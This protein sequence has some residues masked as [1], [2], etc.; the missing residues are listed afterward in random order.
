M[1]GREQNCEITSK[2]NAEE[3]NV[4]HPFEV[5]LNFT[6]I[7]RKYKD[8]PSAIRE[9]ECLKVQFPAILTG[10]Q[11]KD[12]FAGRRQYKSI[13][14]SSLYRHKDKGPIDRVGYYIDEIRLRKEMENSEISENLKFELEDIIN[15]WKEEST[16]TKIRDAYSEKMKEAMPSDDWPHTSGVIFS[17]YRM[18]GAF[19]NYEKL[20]KVGI[21]GL[22]EEIK[23]R[24][25]KAVL[26][27]EDESLFIAMERA[28]DLIIE[29]CNF[30]EEKVKQLIL[31]TTDSNRKNQLNRMLDAIQ[32]IKNSKPNNLQEAVQLMWFY[33]IISSSIEF[34]RM[35]VYL[36]DFY[37]RDVETGRITEEEALKVLM[38]L[39][40][41]IKEVNIN[42]D[43]RI[44][45][46]GV[47]RSNE[48][49]ADR[50]AL[51]AMETTRRFRNSHPQLSLRF[52][53]EMNP[54]LMKKALE[55]L[56]EGG[57]FPILY[58]DDVN[59]TAVEK[60]FQ[61]SREEA[62][63]YVFFG[64]GEYV[65]NYRS[66]GTPSGVINLL[67]ALELV[68]RNGKDAITGKEVGIKLGEFKGFKTFEDLFDAYKKQVEYFVEIIADQEALEYKVVGENTSFV[69]MSMLY[70]DCIKIGRGMF[71]GGVRYLGGTLE[72]YGN[73]STSDSLYA[74]KE[75]VYERKLFTQEG[76]LKMLDADFEGYEKERRLLLNLPKYGNDIDDVDEMAVKIHEHICAITQ[77]QKYRTRLDSYLVVNINNSANTILG[78][79]TA[80]S[81]DGRKKCTSMSNGNGPSPGMDKNG[82]TAL[83]NSLIKL[84]PYC[85]AGA[86]QN[87]KISKELFTNYF[88]KLEILLQIYFDLGGAQANISVINKEDL[89]NALEEPEKY[90]NLMVRVGGFSAPFISLDKDVQEDILHRTLY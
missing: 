12:L 23:I 21:S 46:G 13:G 6:E 5:E 37:V 90:Q 82:F 85:H 89:E 83:I 33:S 2:M 3:K 57:T 8:A 84:D 10:I 75:A 1:K 42:R 11:E 28:L 41:L 36:G 77:K 31:N 55:I 61:V 48:K 70:D 30:Y 26:R 72:T 68:L 32:H 27:G 7:Y 51:L 64:C 16:N 44:I 15:Y 14:F 73:I 54:E 79:Y 56:G 49:N 65:L 81:A 58:N 20:L 88:D 74:I 39:W 18:A 4:S 59:V 53:K 35:D 60:A 38:S 78:R 9:I 40:N 34:G 80:A 47:G 66:F 71:S 69:F 17:L 45:I 25:E 19:V 62:Q 22:R 87:F 24:R 50:F 43:S 29:V 67:K 63:D 52:Y 86:A 76:L